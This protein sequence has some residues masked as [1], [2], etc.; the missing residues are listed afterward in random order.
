MGES[1]E[2]RG[3][4]GGNSGGTH[5]SEGG[6][7][8]LKLQLSRVPLKLGCDGK[9]VKLKF[10]SEGSPQVTRGSTERG[11]GAGRER[12]R[13]QRIDGR[14]SGE[15]RTGARRRFRKQLPN[16]DKVRKSIRRSA[17]RRPCVGGCV[18]RRRI[19]PLRAEWT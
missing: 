7:Q 13:V 14:S 16:S 10:G 1:E 12:Q 2:P 6:E 18:G 9:L 15:R 3:T 8:L 17:R 11:R 5:G 4:V 19:P